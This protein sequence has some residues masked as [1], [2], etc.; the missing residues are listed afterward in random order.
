MINYYQI[1]DVTIWSSLI[2]IKTN[3]KKLC[4]QYHPD[5]C[6]DD[7]SNEYF[8]K[9]QEAYYTLSSKTK[10]LE[11][12]LKYYLPAFQEIQ[13][14][15]QDHELLEE[16]YDKYYDKISSSQEYKL[17]TLLYKS[18]P[19]PIKD[20]MK[21]ITEEILHPSEPTIQKN[22]NE[23]YK[24]PKWIDISSVK[25]YKTINIFVSLKDAY[26]NKLSV[27]LIKTL[28]GCIYYLFLRYYNQDIVV[29]NETIHVCLSFKTKNSSMFYRKQDNLYCLVPLDIQPSTFISLPDKSIVSAINTVHKQKGFTKLYSL[30]KGDLIFV[31]YNNH[32]LQ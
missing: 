3:Y 5:K 25:T 13:L 15:E 11:Y 27:I 12:N 17:C 21:H 29:L 7:S 10:R 14:T 23:L 22:N 4:L 8:L 18:I 19:D 30:E 2:D 6:F 9:I 24:S 20:K 16:Y 28:S 32:S 31:K 1:L 26:L